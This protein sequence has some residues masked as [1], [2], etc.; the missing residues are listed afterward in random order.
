MLHVGVSRISNYKHR[1]FGV[2]LIMAIFYNHFI[3]SGFSVFL[4]KETYKKPD[5]ECSDDGS[6]DVKQD[7]GTP[8]IG[9]FTHDLC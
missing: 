8:L 7:L 4:Q 5:I 9:I 3:P 2:R 6:Y 1:A